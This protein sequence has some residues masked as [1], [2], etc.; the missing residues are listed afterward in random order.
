MSFLKFEEQVEEAL[1][2][3]L[4]E[5]GMEVD[6]LRID[7]PREAA[8][9]ASPVAF[10]LASD[11]GGSPA[12]IAEKVTNSV[13]LGGKGLIADATHESGYVNFYVDSHELA[14]ST[15]RAALDEG[16]NFGSPG[17]EG[18]FVLEHTSANPNGPLHVGHLRNAVIGDGLRRLL[19][20][21]GCSVETQ[22]YF[23]DAGRQIALVVLGTDKF[24]IDADVK[25][26]HAAADVYARANEGVESGEIGEEEV[27]ELL[28]DYEEGEQEVV[29]RF[30]RSVER[31]LGGIRE[32]LGRLRVV[33]DEFVEESRFV[34]DVDSVIEE[35]RDAGVVEEDDGAVVAELPG[36]DKEMVLRRSD[37]TSVYSARDLAYHIWRSTRGEM[38]D[39][40]GADH[41]L[42]ASQ[43]AEA[44]ELL[45]VDP[46]EL[47][48]HEF[49]SLPGRS[50]STRKGEYV[51][52]DELLD[53]AEERAL[54][55]VSKRREELREE[56][57][58]S[59][60]SAVGVSAVRYYMGG[61][62]PEKPME[63][64]MDAAVDFER[65]GAPFV[66]Y[67]YTRCCGILD[68]V[69]EEPTI[70]PGRFGE[71]ELQLAKEVSRLP[72]ILRDSAIER[73]IYPVA[74]YCVEL[75]SAFND[76]YRDCRVKEAPIE[77]RKARIGLVEAT[78][79]ALGEAMKVPGIEPLESM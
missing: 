69:A 77:V 1:Q 49:V 34:A 48:F 68:K 26:D 29:E 71:V 28:K 43:V 27:S 55:E 75:A 7:E 60:A 24:G 76:F 59:I 15:I 31:C 40:L 52:A 74:E 66:Q 13:D 5:L 4:E 65:Q 20:K 3:A 33:H 36:I 53:E 35:L 50:M 32:T 64:D 70:D 72:L 17:L 6:D 10:G 58:R 56:R 61:V 54:H 14:D 11:L 63:F 22:Y 46:P 51:S 8:D 37:G 79:V 44:L 9:L 16:E 67:A 41:K 25:P 30:D 45:G 21:A 23:N 73:R 38:V 62:A 18:D 57:R 19:E 2:G 12:E 39:V 78:R 42:Q 47:I